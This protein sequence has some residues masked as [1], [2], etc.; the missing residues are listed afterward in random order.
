MLEFDPP[1]SHG[2]YRKD[3]QALTVEFERSTRLR[4]RCSSRSRFPTN[5]M[6]LLR[7]YTK[8]DPASELRIHFLERPRLLSQRIAAIHKLA[9]L[10]AFPA[11]HT[12]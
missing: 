6:L 3:L 1:I 10:L 2:Q 7:R 5:P 12:E 11:I 9:G 4:T 8:I